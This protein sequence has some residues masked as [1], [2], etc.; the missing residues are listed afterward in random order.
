MW[1]PLWGCLKV[2]MLQRYFRYKQ[3]KLAQPSLSN[4]KTLEYP[5]QRKGQICPVLGRTGTRALRDLVAGLH[6]PSLCGLVFMRLPLIKVL[7]RIPHLSSSSFDQTFPWRSISCGCGQGRVTDPWA[8]A[9]SSYVRR[10]LQRVEALWDESP[11]SV[12]YYTRLVFV[13]RRKT[14][15][16]KIPADRSCFWIPRKWQN[17]SLA[18][19][20]CLAVRKR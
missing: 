13:W 17:F 4:G 9:H 11:L 14:L 7:C 16:F 12:V 3:W 8:A 2:F 15:L 1:F 19:M 18:K 10:F 6:R 20:S 5:E